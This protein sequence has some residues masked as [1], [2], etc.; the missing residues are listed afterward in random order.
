[1]DELDL[2]MFSSLL[3]LRQKHRSQRNCSRLHRSRQYQNLGKSHVRLVDM[4]GYLGQGF[5]EALGWQLVY[6]S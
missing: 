1:M 2:L 4:A 3:M 5:E 6:G